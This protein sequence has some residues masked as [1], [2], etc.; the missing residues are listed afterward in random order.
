[1]IPMFFSSR[2]TSRRFIYSFLG[3]LLI[4]QRGH[5]FVQI[6]I[7]IL[8][9]WV[10]VKSIPS[11][12]P[13]VFHQYDHLA[14][15]ALIYVCNYISWIPQTGKYG[16]QAHPVD[17]AMDTIGTR[18]GDGRFAP[19]LGEPNIIRFPLRARRLAKLLVQMSQ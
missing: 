13:I 4:I 11:G 15:V 3:I 10:L 6:L 18:M 2:E 12:C 1:M 19:K 16:L 7:L 5:S 17:S 9:F 14:G 8:S